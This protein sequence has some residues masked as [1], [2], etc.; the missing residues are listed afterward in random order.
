MTRT[1]LLAFI[2]LAGFAQETRNHYEFSDRPG[3]RLI[4]NIVA[5]AAKGRVFRHSL[6]DGSDPSQVRVTDVVSGK[7]IAAT[8]NRRS[9][10]ITLPVDFV[11]RMERRL[12][13]EQVV[14]RSK[15]VTS[16]GSGLVFRANL[17][18]GRH[19]VVLP[20]GWV[21]SSIST[22]S[23]IEVLSGR[24]HVGLVHTGAGSL[25]VEIATET[26][27]SVPAAQVAGSFRAL[28]ERI[29]EYK[30]EDPGEHRIDLWLEMEMVP[31]QSHFYSQLREEDNIRNP[32]TLDL[33]RG[34]ELPTRILTG[35][36]AN[37]LGDAPAP[38][39]PTA[40]VLVAD[41]GYTVPPGGVG[42]VRSFQ[43]AT[44]AKNYRLL[45]DGTFRLDRFLARTRSR[46]ILPAG[47][48]LTSVDQPVTVSR[49]K[50]GRAVLDFTWKGAG[51]T[52]L[53][54]TAKRRKS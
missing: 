52:P 45:E 3:L 48:D 13:V 23:Q 4:E 44:D 54:I 12:A 31:G 51:S 26:G 53:V 39:A 47:W 28:D 25:P 10:E 32:V 11:P 30:L 9:I 49:D 42:R 50:Q 38:F 33:D 16:K 27:A 29:V 43:T 2:S 18:E 34:I 24:L 6:A 14:D 8:V 7:S 40:S 17:P 41:M 20:A 1:I 46:F 19:V 21:A 5:R 22:A 15:Y 37:A 35:K 36:E